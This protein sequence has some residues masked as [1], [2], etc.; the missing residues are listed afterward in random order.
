M[1]K[2]FALLATGLISFLIVFSFITR[3][4]IA[5]EVAAKLDEDFVPQCIRHLQGKLPNPARTRDVCQCMKTEFDANGY[6][7]T[8][9]FG[10]DRANM[11]RITRSCAELYS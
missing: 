2:F 3:D 6:A 7:L 1:M 4:E 8:D 5:N 10:D 9:T 11:Q